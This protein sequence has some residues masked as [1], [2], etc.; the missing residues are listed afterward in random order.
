MGDSERRNV[1]VVGAGASQEFGLPTGAQLTKKLRDN[2][3]FG[4]DRFQSATRDRG[5]PLQFSAMRALANKNGHNASH[6]VGHAN[7]ISKN[8]SLAPSIDNF[9]DTHRENEELV[10]LGKIAIASAIF[11]AESNSKLAVDQSNSNN[12]LNFEK[13]AET[14]A[15]VFFKIIAAKRNFASFLGALESITFISFNYDRCIQQFF[16]N[17]ASSYFG[18]HPDEVDQVLAAIKVIHPYGSIGELT[19]MQGRIQGF[20]IEPTALGVVAA[21]ERIRTFTEGVSDADVTSGIETAFEDASIVVFLGFSFIDINM[22]ILRPK[23][24]TADRILATAKGR[25]EDTK[26][27]L[28]IQ[29]SREYSRFNGPVRA[30]MFDGKCFELF[31]EFDHYLMA[32]TA[33]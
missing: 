23:K 33:Q 21:S 31:Y 2:L 8:M 13:T 28:A 16:V 18:L 11:Q 7:N 24:G 27:R 32:E 4:I 5:D 19:C 14:W 6:Y 12:R 17:A 15:A 29:I 1:I 10:S 26:S 25:S 30:E 9:L 20:G 22:D 3:R